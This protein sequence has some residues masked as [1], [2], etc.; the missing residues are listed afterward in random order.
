MKLLL[1]DGVSV[2]SIKVKKKYLVGKFHFV[3]RVAGI[4]NLRKT[5]KE[6]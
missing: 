2:N 4:L 1:N 5:M 6:T 3:G